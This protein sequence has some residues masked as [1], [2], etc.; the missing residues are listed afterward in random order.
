MV[1]PSSSRRKERNDKSRREYR[2]NFESSQFLKMDKYL[3]LKQTGI[4]EGLPDVE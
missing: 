3:L 1:L 2:S 4:V